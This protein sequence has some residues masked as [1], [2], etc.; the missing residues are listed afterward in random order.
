[1]NHLDPHTRALLLHQANERA[2]WMMI[3]FLWFALFFIV[4]AVVLFHRQRIARHFDNLRAK[5]E[6]NRAPLTT[7]RVLRS[8]G[9]NAHR[10]LDEQEKAA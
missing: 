4:G 5:A 8:A 6:R 10:V 3:T 2:Y 9:Q 7:N 1:M